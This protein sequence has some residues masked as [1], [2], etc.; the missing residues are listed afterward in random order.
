[1]FARYDR[2]PA[3]RGLVGPTRDLK[4]NAEILIKNPAEMNLRPVT[5]VDLLHQGG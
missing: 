4:L 1:M 2:H 5:A 3:P